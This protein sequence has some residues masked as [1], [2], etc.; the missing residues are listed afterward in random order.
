MKSGN[1]F[2]D[3][4]PLKRQAACDEIC[5]YVNKCFCSNYE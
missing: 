4:D 5:D 2:F 1:S 3:Q